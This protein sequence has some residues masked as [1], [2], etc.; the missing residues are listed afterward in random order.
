MEMRKNR[1]VATA[2]EMR[3]LDAMDLITVHKQGDDWST[4]T[5]AP[6]DVIIRW[7]GQGHATALTT[8]E[9]CELIKYWVQIHVHDSDA[10]E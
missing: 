8:E 9:E 7:N 2:P 10:Q 3:E 1:F 6:F 5:G 4:Y